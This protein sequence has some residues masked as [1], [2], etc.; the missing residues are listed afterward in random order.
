MTSQPLDV[1]ILGAGTAGLSARAEVAKV[2]D[3][4]RVFDPGPL[5]TTCARAACMPSK[6]LLQSAHDF[7][8]REA[9]PDL[10]IAGGDA[11][12]ADGAMVLARTRELRDRLVGGV[13]DGMADWRETHLVPHAAVFGPD[14]VLCAGAHRFRPAAT[15]IATGTRPIVPEPWRARFGDRIVTTEEVFELDALPRRMAVVGLGPVG[16]ELG[17]AMARLGVEVTG[18]D[19]SATLGGLDDPDLLDRLR[20]AL[21][22]EMRIV[23]AEAAPEP[24]EGGAIA[25]R[26]DEGAVEVDL[27][28][29]AMGRAPN[30]DGLG[31]DR[32]GLD[33][34]EDG[35]PDLPRGCLNPPGARLYFAG[36][37]G[38]GPALLHEAADEGRI[39]GHF[40]ARGQDAA[41]RRRVPLRLVF[42]EPQIAVAGATWDELAD[43]HER[44]AVGGASLDSTGRVLVQRGAGGAMRLYAEKATARLLGAAIVGPEAEHMGH[45]LAF[46][47]DKDADLGALLRMPAYHPTH[48]EVLRRALREALAGCDVSLDELDAIT[49]QD[50]PVDE[51]CARG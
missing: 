23:R 27:V 49:C 24:G 28:L 48:E 10:G 46:A 45:L 9:L 17:Q 31:L 5:G 44:I 11:L 41:F 19:P 30:L 33:L 25:M 13:L 2:T 1:A 15:V 47:I 39:A 43:R 38:A 20:E 12:R 29:A 4:Y 51:G 42:C 18:F 50:V 16:L 14:G 7:K 26:W 40:A 22:G 3:S 34:G 32:L 37:A 21:K 8:R 36:D 6:A 35:R